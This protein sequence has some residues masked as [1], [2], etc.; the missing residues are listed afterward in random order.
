MGAVGWLLRAPARFLG[1]RFAFHFV[2]AV[3]LFVPHLFGSRESPKPYHFGVPRIHSGDEPHYL[4]FL[5]SLV[6]D[7][8][9][10]LANN[11]DAVHKGSMD[12]GLLFRGSALNHHTIWFVGD[13]RVH[14]FE[15]FRQEGPWG[16]D[17]EGHPFPVVR[18]GTDP[19]WI[20]TMESPWNSVGLPLLVSPVF[21]LLKRLGHADWTEPVATILS[22]IAVLI[23]SIFWRILAGGFTNDRRIINIGIAFAFLG[24]PAWHYGR[25]FFS[26]PYLIALMTGAYAFA[27]VKRHYM[28]SGFL[29]GMAIV[30]KP[31]AAVMGVPIGILLLAR[32]EIGNAVRFSIPVA[33]WVGVQL[34]INRW[35]YGSILHTSNEFVPGYI[36]SNGL[37]LI[38]H[39]TRGL[40]A[41]APIAL[42]AAA[43]WPALAKHSRA[44][45]AALAACIVFYLL[46]AYNYAW[47]G[48]YA[49]SVRF[50]VPLVPLFSL[51]LVP[52]LK[53]PYRRFVIAVGMLSIV[54]NG[55]AA[56]QY[57]RAFHNHPFLYLV[58]STE[59]EPAPTA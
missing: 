18:D 26:E 22:A 52:L 33:M 49:Y 21:M 45:L 29:I 38:A 14:W 12:A 42:V 11:Y 23:A 56:V 31:V 47:S 35:L 57:W 9:L 20:P 16:K 7:G 2:V 41:T 25:S 3:L 10:S 19:R 51:G 8:D 37:Q 54:I 59:Y 30:I 6:D 4:V 58:P 34:G 50:L 48:G 17:P 28:L 36:V 24:T 39:P 32:G 5:H 46:V 44:A 53:S 55:L 27:I 40:L 13:H 15:I 1:S 43:G